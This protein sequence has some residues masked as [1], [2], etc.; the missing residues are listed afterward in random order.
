MLLATTMLAGCAHKASGPQSAF[1]PHVQGDGGL[2]IASASFVPGTAV[3]GTALAAAMGEP[4]DCEGPGLGVAV[5]S[6]TGDKKGMYSANGEPCEKATLVFDGRSAAGQRAADPVITIGFVD[7]MGPLPDKAALESL[8][9]VPTVKVSSALLQPAMAK[10]LGTIAPAAGKAP[11]T[12]AS[13]QAS[14]PAPD[15]FISTLKEWKADLSATRAAENHSRLMAD[16]DAA[17]SDARQ[18]DKLLKKQ[19]VTQT[20]A[21]VDELMER[22][23]QAERQLQQSQQRTSQLLESSEQKRNKTEAALSKQQ[24]TQSQLQ[25]EL[26]ATQ[27]RMKQFEELNQRLASDKREQERAYQQ[28]LAMLSG[29][30]KAA[31]R[32]ADATRKELIL[33]A[34]A[35]IAEAEQLANAARIQ[36]QEVK[37]REAARMKQEAEQMMQR[38]VDIQ[39]G[40]QLMADL[41]EIKPAA[42][43]M[44]LG[45][46]PVVIHAKDK[47]LPDMLAEILG[48]A[49]AQAG[50]WKADLQLPAKHQYI[51]K[52][53]WSLT[54][55]APLT[56]VLQQLTAQIRAAH[57][58]SLTFTQFGQSRLLVVTSETK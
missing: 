2:V 5:E 39:A 4:E 51:L 37:L 57:G 28:K 42:A 52:E 45:D 31:E 32:Q 7:T 49:K 20:Q 48:I 14:A 38:A 9:P 50:E 21:Q 1:V 41:A 54:A 10:G 18:L 26:A 17:L 3:R 13:A 46:V 33:Q 34:A 15:E 19:G 55:E 35:K 23:R 22:L 56:E 27:E 25:A 6:V 43:P 24:T 58:I 11:V 12:T 40:K 16:S 47:T 8:P 30:L 53:K 29:D 36:E 44:A